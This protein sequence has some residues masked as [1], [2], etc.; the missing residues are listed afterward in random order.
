MSGVAVAAA[1]RR[2]SSPA[3]SSPAAFLPLLHTADH[4]ELRRCQLK[5]NQFWLSCQVH[6]LQ[7]AAGGDAE[8]VRGLQA[9]LAFVSAE[10]EQDERQPAEAAQRAE[11]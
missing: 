8:L 3:P 2:I 4:D 6:N 1:L 9:D 10:L 11:H 7:R 5:E